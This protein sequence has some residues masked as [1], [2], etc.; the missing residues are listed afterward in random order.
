ME[1]YR[2]NGVI[3][4]GQETEQGIVV[5]HDDLSRLLDQ[6]TEKNT[7][8]TYNFI[9]ATENY[10]V[11]TCSI[12]ERFTGRSVTE[13][14]ECKGENQCVSAFNLAF[15]KAA[16]R[17][18]DIEAISDL[19]VQKH[20]GERNESNTAEKS[21]QKSDKHSKNEPSGKINIED[22]RPLFGDFMEGGEDFSLSVSQFFKKAESNKKTEKKLEEYLSLVPAREADKAKQ[23]GLIA[24]Q[25]YL[26]KGYILN[27]GV[28]S[29]RCMTA[30]EAFAAS[31]KE[32]PLKAALQMY[33]SA[34]IEQLKG[35]R[36]K[37]CLLALQAQAEVEQGGSYGQKE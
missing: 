13:I 28:F 5:K 11:V 33:L 16:I 17:F 22:Y 8:I 9:K 31:T 20:E 36:D 29:K 10:A 25:R 1:L 30:Q 26:T 15:D 24:I 34:D 4:E 27:T 2:K 14:G 18:L 35:E 6:L 37:I 7:R 3:L 21:E 32:E 19:Q 12:H 23:Y